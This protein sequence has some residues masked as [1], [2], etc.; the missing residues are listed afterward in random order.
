MQIIQN[1][2]ESLP[3]EDKLAAGELSARIQYC[4]LPMEKNIY[5]CYS[6]FAE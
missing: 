6:S 5:G 3:L 4:T 1:S 2:Q